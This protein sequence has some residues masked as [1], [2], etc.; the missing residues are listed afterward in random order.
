MEVKEY[1]KN[2]PIPTDS[3]EVMDF[4]MDVEDAYDII[5]DFKEVQKFTTSEQFISLIERKIN[6]KQ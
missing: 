5:I 4:L 1:I 2:H 6:A 3:L